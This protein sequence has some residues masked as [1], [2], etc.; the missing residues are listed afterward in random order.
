MSSGSEM[1]DTFSSNS[2]SLTRKM[3]ITRKQKR[4]LNGG[5][6]SSTLVVHGMT[7]TLF[8][9]RPRLAPQLLALFEV[10][11]SK[12]QFVLVLFE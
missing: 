7:H 10:V 1:A 2:Y 9:V 8:D 12:L 3:L 6:F 11:V 4:T 5:G